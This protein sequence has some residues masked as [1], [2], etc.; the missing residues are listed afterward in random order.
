MSLFSSNNHKLTMLNSLLFSREKELQ[1]LIENNLKET[2]DMHFLASEY[3]TSAR[4][5]IDTLAVDSDGTPTIIEYKRSK[6]DNVINQSLSYL[7]WLKAQRQEF[8][9]M[10]MHNR[11][12]K[13]VADSIRLDW[14]HPRIVCIAETFTQFD[15]DTVEVVP[16]RIDLY[17]YRYY[18]G[19]LISFEMVAVNEKQKNLVEACQ[20]MPVET[21]QTIAQAMKDQTSAS[22]SIRSLFDELRERIMAMDQ[23]IIEKPGKRS[24]AY[25]LTKNFVEVL[26]RKERLVID[27]RPI[28]YQDPRGLVEE[29]GDGYVMTMNRRI[30]LADPGDLDYV[31]SIIE[32]SYQNVV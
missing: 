28:D 12:G 4:G 13:E 3:R 2:L 20:S 23:Y 30:T 18:E 14:K 8:F 31:F 6:D 19:G 1:G 24:I 17:K 11:L 7:K 5:R 9:E 21:N 25:R 22:D 10:L 29:L 32:Q 15:I 27:L 16:L 26:I